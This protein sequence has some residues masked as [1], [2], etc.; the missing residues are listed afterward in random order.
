MVYT[1]SL[2]LFHG[3]AFRIV[4]RAREFICKWKTMGSHRNKQKNKSAQSA[5]PTFSQ[6]LP[7][8]VSPHYVQ[9]DPIYYDGQYI[10]SIRKNFTSLW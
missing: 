1:D 7:T 3:L 9:Q 10:A 4:G 6:H 5:S 2:V 8:Q